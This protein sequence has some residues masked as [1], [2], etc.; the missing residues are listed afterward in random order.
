MSGGYNVSFDTIFTG[1]LC[2]QW[3]DIGVWALLLHMRDKNGHVDV[4]PQYIHNVTGI[5]MPDLMACI[6]RFTSPDP[7][8][9][10]KGED[11]RRMRLI[12]P[13]RP[14]GWQI[15]NHQLYRERARL[16]SKNQREIESGQNQGRMSDR[17]RPPPTAG[18]HPSEA[19]AEAKADGEGAR[20]APPAPFALESGTAA[21]RKPRGNSRACQIPEDF[22]LDDELSSYATSRLPGVDL[23]QL[24]DDFRNHHTAKGEP[25]KNWRAAWR[26]WVGKALKY[27]YPGQPRGGVRSQQQPQRARAFPS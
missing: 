16:I 21:E 27:G 12:D 2:G 7:A 18:D 1:S 19:E 23:A 3:P 22:G 17:R 9:R 4:T 6:E 25:L 24:L 8:S 5:P 10:T 14:W 13:N 15:I 11:G 26:T 20:D